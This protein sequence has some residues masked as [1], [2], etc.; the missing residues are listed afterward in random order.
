LRSDVELLRIFSAFGI[1][2]FHSGYP[3]WIDVAY[4]GLVV[5]LILSAYFAASSKKLYTI[6]ERARRLLIPCLVWAAFYALFLIVRGRDIFPEDYSLFSKLLATPALHLW[7]LPFMFFC[8]ILIDKIK[9]RVSIP[10]IAVCSLSLAAGFLVCASIWTAWGSPPPLRQYTHALPAVGIGVLLAALAQL[11]LHVGYICLAIGVLLFIVL[12][13]LE[14]KGVG[15]TY[16]I[17][18]LAT[19]LLLRQKSFLPDSDIVLVVSSLSFG[20]YLIHPFVITVLRHINITAF[21]LPMLGFL[22]SMVLVF[23]IQRLLP[24]KFEK[25][26]I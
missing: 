16:L 18:I 12:F 15:W 21:A 10:V 19:L 20:V 1:V 6:S 13:Q 25:F 9:T 2:W 26:V 7:Y 23:V 8:I 5:F 17:G 4:S 11:K 3:K 22:L 14:L 24:K